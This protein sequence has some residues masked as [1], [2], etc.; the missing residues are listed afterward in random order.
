M[1]DKSLIQMIILASVLATNLYIIKL[2]SK[3][4]S[5]NFSSPIPTPK[6]LKAQ[7]SV[8]AAPVSTNTVVPPATPVP[9]KNKEIVEEKK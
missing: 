7:P 8:S 5:F 3:N 6:P 2:L 9:V 4:H 1:L